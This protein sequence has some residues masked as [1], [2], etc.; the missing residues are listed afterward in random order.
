MQTPA[1]RSDPWDIHKFQLHL[2]KHSHQREVEESQLVFLT[3]LFH[4]RPR[5]VP[6]VSVLCR[7]VICQLQV[8][9]LQEG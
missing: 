8:V 7:Q 4:S 3:C 9:A 6:L 1:E 2:Q 5:L